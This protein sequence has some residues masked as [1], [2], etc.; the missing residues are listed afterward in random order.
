MTDLSTGGHRSLFE[1]DARTRRRNAAETRFRLYGMA[2]VTAGILALIFL[3]T[4]ILGNGLSSFRQTTLDL[5]VT[6]DAAVLDKAIAIPTICARSPRSGMARFWIRP[7]PTR[8][9]P[10]A[11][12]PR[13]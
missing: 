9:Q 7:L 13:R 3:L 10:M 12:T 2:A 1:P 8:W 5:Q 11:S 4:S 6:L